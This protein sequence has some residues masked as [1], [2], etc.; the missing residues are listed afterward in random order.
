MGE[1]IVEILFEAFDT[2]YQL[3][4]IWSL[5]SI[6]MLDALVCAIIMWPIIIAVVYALTHW[7]CTNRNVKLAFGLM[8]MLILHLPAIAIMAVVVV[9]KDKEPLLKG[10]RRNMKLFR[11]YWAVALSRVK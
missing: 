10:I 8:I 6:D 9:V 7:L 4:E 2:W 11:H 5:G 1:K 3:C